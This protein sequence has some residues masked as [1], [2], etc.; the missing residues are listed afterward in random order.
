MALWGRARK[1]LIHPL[2]TDQTLLLKLNDT[3][4]A[5]NSG[6]PATRL[7]RSGFLACQPEPPPLASPAHL[8]RFVGLFEPMNPD[9]DPEPIA[10]DKPTLEIQQLRVQ[11]EKLRLEIATL[12]ESAEWNREVGRYLP[13][14]TAIVAVVGLLV[15]VWQF[16]LGRRDE[17]MK[18][19]AR[20]FWEKQL[21]TYLQAAGAAAEIA[22]APT[23]SEESKK[24]QR[25]FWKLYWGPMGCVEDAT[26]ANA[27]SKEDSSVEAAMV[28]FGKALLPP[29]HAPGTGAEKA[30]PTPI[31]I[32]SVDANLA[33]QL[34]PLALEIAH[35]MRRQLQ[36]SFD[37]KI[38]L[39][40]SQEGQKIQP[41]PALNASTPAP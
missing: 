23:D 11:V 20:P 6:V 40:S 3:N 12:K 31:V 34:Q 13:M 29:H 8:A 4:K 39:P 22:V 2:S 18:E 26:L 19:V 10:F 17:V 15:G 32:R 38:D 28:A 30:G 9:P 27:R 16:N 37:L 24:A 14:T 35:A 36:P 33:R 25:T 1:T 7:P 41:T 21:E 5:Q